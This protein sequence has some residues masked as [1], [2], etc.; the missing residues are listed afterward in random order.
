VLD[1]GIGDEV[2]HATERRLFADGRFFHPDGKARFVFEPPRP[3]P[4]PPSAQ[5]PLTLLTGRSSAAVWHTQTRTGKSAVLRKLAPRCAYVE[6]NPADARAT[7]VRPGQ[8]IFVESQRGSV[9]ASAFVTE[10]IPRGQVFMS[11]HDAATNLLTD[12]V[13]DPYSRQP[14]YKACA[15]RVRPA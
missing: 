6:I 3:L 11:M 2:D 8:Q 13:F 4:E 1:R 7:G 14:A 5:Y 10:T 15:V 12:A 9:T